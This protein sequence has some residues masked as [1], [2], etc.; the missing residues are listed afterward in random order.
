MTGPVNIPTLD[1]LAAD[2]SKVESLPQ[3]VKKSIWPNVRA[4]EAVL[5]LGIITGS[6]QGGKTPP[7]DDALIG[8][9]DVAH[10]IGMSVSW[11]EKH[12]DALPARRS[13]EG[14]PRWLKSEILTWLKTRPVYGQGT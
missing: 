4:L 9:D 13:V 10:L 11:V 7:P 6:H 5:A 12:P 14:N 3:E 8:V 2:L 1:Q